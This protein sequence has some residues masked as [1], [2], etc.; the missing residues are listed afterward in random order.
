MVKV[1]VI[2]QYRDS[3]KA[4][5]FHENDVHEVSDERA[6]KL[7]KAGVCKVDIPEEEPE[8][9]KTAKRKTE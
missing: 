5:I 2:K 1:K 3:E 7:I 6:E 4:S 9:K 8:K